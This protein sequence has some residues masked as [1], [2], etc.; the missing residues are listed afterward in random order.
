MKIHR[1]S[2]FLISMTIAIG[3][4]TASARSFSHVPKNLMISCEAES[5]AKDTLCFG[6]C[7]P[8]Q[9]GICTSSQNANPLIEGNPGESS[10]KDSSKT[11]SKKQGKVDKNEVNHGEHQIVKIGLGKFRFN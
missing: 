11:T 1:L 4:R 6:T 2:L 9:S 5:R 10:R 3:I 8:A 7:Y